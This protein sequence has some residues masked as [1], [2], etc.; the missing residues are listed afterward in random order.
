MKFPGDNFCFNTHL[1]LYSPM[2]EAKNPMTNSTSVFHSQCYWVLLSPNYLVPH[3]PTHQLCGAHGGCNFVF[4]SNAHT[5]TKTFPI[6]AFVRQN[7]GG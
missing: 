2:H 6:A 5:H 1:D 7:D 3:E 4:I